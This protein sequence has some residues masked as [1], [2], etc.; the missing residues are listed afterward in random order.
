MRFEVQDWGLCD[1]SDALA[2][3]HAI[4]D[5]RIHGTCNDTLILVEHPPVF[6]IGRQG[7][8]ANLLVPPQQLHIPVVRVE[9]GGDITFHGPGQLVAYPIFALPTRRRNVRSFLRML[10]NTVAIACASFGAN[11]VLI[12]GLT[13][14]WIAT[15]QGPYQRHS[16]LGERKIASLGCA[17]KHW[18]C[19]HGVSVNVENDLTPFSFIHLCGLPGKQPIALKD[20][21]TRPVSLASFKSVFVQTLEKQWHDFCT[22]N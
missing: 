5:A 3:Q 7:S 22:S 4:L 20:C 10:E 8:L 18:V 1:Y 9:R 17:F 6:T 21:A 16:W 13:G 2:R 12:N 11:P 19:Y 14:V 15:D